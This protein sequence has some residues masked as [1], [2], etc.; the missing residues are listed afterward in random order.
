MTMTTTL[1]NLTKA[2]AVY[3]ETRWRILTGV[4]LP[5]T[6]VNQAEL[7][8]EFG[9]SPTPVREALRRLESEGFVVFIAHSMVMVAPLDLDELD[10]LYAI[11]VELDS[12]AGRL[13]AVNF[14]RSDASNWKKL[15]HPSQGT[16]T[17]RFERNRLFHRSV[18]HASH[19]TQLIALLDQ[20]WDR[21]ER[22]RIV[23]VANEASERG[24][25]Y[26]E[27]HSD[28]DHHAIADALLKG[29]AER[30]GELV[31]KHV[32]L[33]HDLIRSVLESE[34]NEFTCG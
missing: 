18:Y 16:L 1:A 17:D 9:M 15:L 24:A 2:E 33:S 31:R 7:A 30:V 4:M 8:N 10:E 25:H 20:L 12:F 29:N 14:T 32:Q 3:R 23:L 34:G 26:A 6:P 19:N 13:A 5:G 21:T 22:Y 27:S 28:E 11:R